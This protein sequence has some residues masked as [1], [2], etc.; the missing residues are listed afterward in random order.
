MA[1]DGEA[2]ISHASDFNAPKKGDIIIGTFN[3]DTEKNERSNC[4]FRGHEMT[5]RLKE[6]APKEVIDEVFGMFNLVIIN[7]NINKRS[8]R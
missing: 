5:E 8:S 3:I 4:E 6:N 1:P 7:G 2:Y